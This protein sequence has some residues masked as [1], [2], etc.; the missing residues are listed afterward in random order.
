MRH[1]N[2]KSKR[3]YLIKKK[4]L[5]FEKYTLFNKSVYNEFQIIPSFSYLF[6]KRFYKYNTKLSKSRT[7]CLFTGRYRG[8]MCFFMMSRMYFKKL[9]LN[10]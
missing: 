5:E 8:T 1:L 10:G 4:Y 3:D 9:A 6:Y 7:R 2:Y